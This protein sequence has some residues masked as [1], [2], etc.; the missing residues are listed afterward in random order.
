MWHSAFVN[1]RKL[2]TE[3]K[4]EREPL[5]TMHMPSDGSFVLVP[6]EALYDILNTGADKAKIQ[7]HQPSQQPSSPQHH[8]LLKDLAQRVRHFF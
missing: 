7:P 5:D 8:S 4:E 3:K 1:Y 6:R 2:Y